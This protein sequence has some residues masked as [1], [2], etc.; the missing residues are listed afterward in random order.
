MMDTIYLVDEYSDKII[1][2]EAGRYRVVRN[3]DSMISTSLKITAGTY[4]IRRRWLPPT[5]L[6]IWDT[7]ISGDVATGL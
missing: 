7:S 4:V 3:N 6:R 5:A 1:P 2:I